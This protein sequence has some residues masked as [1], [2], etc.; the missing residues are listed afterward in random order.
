MMIPNYALIGEIMLFAEG[1]SEAKVLST[2]M[3]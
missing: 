1:F 2:K 3:V